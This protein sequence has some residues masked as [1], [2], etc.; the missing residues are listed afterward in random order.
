MYWSRTQRRGHSHW[1][2]AAMEAVDQ[3]T[4]ALQT[5][6]RAVAPSLR[7]RA[8]TNLGAGYILVGRDVVPCLAE[9]NLYLLDRNRDDRTRHL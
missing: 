3:S 6:G 9:G 1:A 8:D 5:R 2:L 7:R 4:L